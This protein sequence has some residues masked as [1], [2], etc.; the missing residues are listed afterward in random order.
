LKLL[1]HGVTARRYGIRGPIISYERPKKT[2]VSGPAPSHPTA[3]GVIRV[4]YPNYGPSGSSQPEFM[5]FI[6]TPGF[7]KK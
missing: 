6:Q 4:P 1:L 7:P 5:E 2:P 3:P